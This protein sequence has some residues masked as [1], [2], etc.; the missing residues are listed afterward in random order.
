MIVAQQQSISILREKVMKR[1][2]Q[3][4]AALVTI[5]LAIPAY[6]AIAQFV[7]KEV[8]PSDATMVAAAIV[9]AALIAARRTSA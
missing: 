6:S 3:A 9:V 2:I 4:T 8:Q 1:W 7:T 5:V